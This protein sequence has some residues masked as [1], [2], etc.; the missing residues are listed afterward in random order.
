MSP[1]AHGIKQQGNQ[2]S[3]TVGYEGRIGN[4][5]THGADG[6]KPFVVGNR[7]VHEDESS[8]TGAQMC[9]PFS[10]RA[11]NSE[12]KGRLKM[13]HEQL[14]EFEYKA[15]VRLDEQNSD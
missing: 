3:R 4:G 1:G 11:G 15:L 7:Q 9:H 12:V 6:V 8:W 5:E 10:E 2:W 14:V 13:A